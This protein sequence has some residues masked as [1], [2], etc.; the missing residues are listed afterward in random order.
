MFPATTCGQ[1]L[2]QP[3]PQQDTGAGDPATVTLM[4]VPVEE[5]EADPGVNH[6][7]DGG[8]G[9]S[10]YQNEGKNHSPNGLELSGV[11]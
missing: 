5:R 2:V 7:S 6:G 3:W 4:Q 1:D 11:E 8:L 9:A 10:G